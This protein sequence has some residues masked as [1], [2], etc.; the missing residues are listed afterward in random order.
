MSDSTERHSVSTAHESG[1]ERCDSDAPPM[2]AARGIHK[3]FAGLHV[4]RGCDLSVDRGQVAALMGPSGSG[5]STLLRCLNR[6][7]EPSSGEVRIDGTVIT[8]LRT[9]VN[10]VRADI[11]MVFQDYNLFPHM[12]SLENVALGPIHVRKRSRREA[13][14]TAA[15]SLERVGLADQLDKRPD[16]L[17]GGQQQRVAIARSLAMSPKAILFDEPTSALDPE[18]VHEVLDVMRSLARE[19]MTMVVV[20]HEIGFLREAAD[21]LLMLEAGVII[22]RGPVARVL[23]EPEQERTRVF[24]GALR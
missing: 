11:G 17:S 21:Q 6:I 7:E 3:Y 18:M 23:D 10:S 16:G 22:E 24:L 8:D 12:T 19:G 13:R 9:D 5:K 1:P 2:I 4:L 20:S 14:D 15:A